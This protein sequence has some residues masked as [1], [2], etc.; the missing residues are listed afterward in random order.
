MCCRSSIEAGI[1]I[2]TGAHPTA[3]LLTA[4]HYSII[5]VLSPQPAL[6][7]RVIGAEVVCCTRA[8]QYD[9]TVTSYYCSAAYHRYATLYYSVRLHSLLSAAASTVPRASQSLLARG[10]PCRSGAAASAVHAAH[11]HRIPSPTYRRDRS[12]R[13]PKS[14]DHHSPPAPV[15]NINRRQISIKCFSSA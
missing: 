15:C 12:P 9:G 11:S 7:Y 6:R 5:M 8:V 10:V 2:M 4:L 13:P 3:L 14:G 1:F